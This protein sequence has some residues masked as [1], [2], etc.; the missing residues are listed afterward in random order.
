M[1]NESEILVLKKIGGKL[2]VSNVA[3]RGLQIYPHR[4]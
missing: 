3:H 2:Q 4:D 1:V